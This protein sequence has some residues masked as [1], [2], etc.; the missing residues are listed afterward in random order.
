MTVLLQFI[1]KHILVE[2]LQ[3]LK[4]NGNENEWIKEEEFEGLFYFWREL[5]SLVYPLHK[6]Y[7]EATGEVVEQ[8]E[9]QEEQTVVKPNFFIKQTY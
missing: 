5:Q 7:T 3:T 9:E 6:T 4:S 8:A 1:K 2:V